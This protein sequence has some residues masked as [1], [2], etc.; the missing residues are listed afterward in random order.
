MEENGE[1]LIFSNKKR[2]KQQR[3]HK[4]LFSQRISELP[5]FHIMTHLQSKESLSS[6]LSQTRIFMRTNG[7]IYVAIIF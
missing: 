1:I 2:I 6:K 4:S 5:D 7:F 3:Q